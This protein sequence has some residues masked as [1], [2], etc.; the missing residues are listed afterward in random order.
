[1][2]QTLSRPFV[3]DFILLGTYAFNCSR[4]LLSK[5]QI[6]VAAVAVVALVLVVVVASV[7]VA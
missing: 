4:R 1:M 5:N 6:D 7:A 2:S 3:S